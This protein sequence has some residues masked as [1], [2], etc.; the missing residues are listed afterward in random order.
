MVISPMRRVSLPSAYATEATSQAAS[1]SGA[2]PI[3]AF[4]VT[5]ALGVGGGFAWEQWRRARARSGHTPITPAKTVV[6]AA[7]ARAADRRRSLPCRILVYATH[8]CVPPLLLAGFWV[9]SLWWLAC[10]SLWACPLVLVAADLPIR[11]ERQR[12]LDAMRSCSRAHF[13][14]AAGDPQV[15]SWDLGDPGVVLIPR[16]PGL[17]SVAAMRT[18]HRA[19][20]TDAVFSAT[21]SWTLRWPPDRN[22]GT[23]RVVAVPSTREKEHVRAVGSSVPGGE[24]V[25]AGLKTMIPTQ[26]GQRSR[27]AAAMRWA[28]RLAPW[29]AMLTGFAWTLMHP[30]VVGLY[31]L[32]HPV[33]IA[34]LVAPMV[35]GAAWWLVTR[36]IFDPAGHSVKPFRMMFREW[37]RLLILEDSRWWRWTLWVLLAAALVTSTRSRTVLAAAVPMVSWVG[38]AWLRGVMVARPRRARMEVM[39]ATAGGILKYTTHFKAR[40]DRPPPGPWT[41]IRVR[42]WRPGGLPAAVRVVYPTGLNVTDLNMRRTLLD[43][44]NYKVCPPSPDN[45]GLRWHASWSGKG[46]VDLTPFVPADP[47]DVRWDGLV[48]PTWSRFLVGRDLDT[49]R[50]VEFDVDTESPH[51]LVA[52]LTRSGKSSVME[53]IAAQASARGWELQIGDFKTHWLRWNGRP[54]LV[55]PVASLDLEVP[56]ESPVFAIR[57]ML[58]RA[59]EEVQQRKLQLGRH[60]VVRFADLPPGTVFTP[61]LLIID[62]FLALV[63]KEKG[64]DPSV[65][66]R[67]AARD[68]ILSNSQ[69][70]AV[71][72][73]AMGVFLMLGIQRPDTEIMGGPLRSQFGGRLACG[74]MDVVSRRMVLD[75]SRT[76]ALAVTSVTGR[77]IAGRAVFRPAPGLP[78]V[79]IQNAWFGDPEA[80]ADLEK[81]LPRR[82]DE[83]GRG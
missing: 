49:G 33:L 13:A 14:D 15:T 74:E 48:L 83:F 61:R 37:L 20:N 1:A 41:H 66:E 9:H 25:V 50:W 29:A 24:P 28:A 21:T 30:M 23:P 53:S 67:N 27:T 56:D 44:W 45:P 4:V 54:G 78:L 80:A 35:F 71:E 26:E 68:Q 76:P 2:S 51:L 3:P 7:W 46:Y 73:A 12:V 77:K 17:P 8:L 52:G 60:G 81:Y 70:L 72:A 36:K 39:H 47:E 32:A 16:T 34:C 18:F 59:D 19:W 64:K 42:T 62:E 5:L 22:D 75:E 82:T 65:R 11:R 43:E 40:K 79:A 58:E 57:D 55:E 10:V 31:L 69:R 38:L 63:A 6:R